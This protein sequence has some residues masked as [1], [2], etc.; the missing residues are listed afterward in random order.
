[1]KRS[2]DQGIL[3]LMVFQIGR[4]RKCR[5]RSMLMIRMLMIVWDRAW[6][7]ECLRVERVDREDHIENQ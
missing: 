3:Y 4:S 2:K 5:M 6:D 1:M 7:R